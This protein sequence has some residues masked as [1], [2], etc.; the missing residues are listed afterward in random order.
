M[1]GYLGI[2]FGLARIGL[3]ISETGQMARPLAVIKNKGDKK[4]LAAIS[5]TINKYWGGL[6]DRL[7]HIVLGLPCLA[8]GAESDMAREVRRFGEILAQNLGVEV[9]F[10][11]E[12]LTSVE[13]TDYAREH[14]PKRTPK[15]PIDDVAAY[16]IL[17]SYIDDL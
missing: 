2:D 8:D 1:K 14:M 16:L 11:N 15:D 6:E 10:Q 17:Q 3:A 12:Y 5:E 7:P 4:N 13:A 9:F